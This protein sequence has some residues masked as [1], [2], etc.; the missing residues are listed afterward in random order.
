M[1]NVQYGGFKP[2]EYNYGPAP[3]TRRYEVASSY[4]TALFPG[5]PVT[6]INDGT[7]TVATIGSADL[8]L[9]VISHVSYVIDNKRE[10]K[11]YLPATTVYSPTARG[12]GN[13]SYV[14]VYDDP[15]T[16]F[17]GNVKSNTDTD[18]EAEVYAALGENMDLDA[19]SG[20]DTYYGRSSFTMDGNAQVAVVRFRLIEIFREPSNDLA[21][22][23]WKVKF[24]INEGFHPFM[25]TAG[26]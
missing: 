2:V 25:S 18:T 19:G 22:A 4:G 14:W 8:I 12:S 24:A 5:D 9:G 23:N 11:K 13:A 7:V 16:V 17:I 20:G 21:S 15:N 1:A 6:L 10:D 3:R 26:I